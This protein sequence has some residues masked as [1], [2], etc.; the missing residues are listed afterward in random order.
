[1]YI[2]AWST[3]FQLKEQEEGKILR[4]KSAREWF[5]LQG[6]CSIKQNVKIHFI[7]CEEGLFIGG[8][9]KTA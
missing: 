4:G 2:Y 7:S 6:I 9:R 3:I 8:N 5:T 1:V